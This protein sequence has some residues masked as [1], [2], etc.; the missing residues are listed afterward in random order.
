VPKPGQGA[1]NGIIDEEDDVAA[2]RNRVK[3]GAN[4]E[5]VL[6]INDL[7][8]VLFKMMLLKI[9]SFFL[10]KIYKSGGRPAVDRLCIGVNKAECFGLL[11]LNGAGKTSTFK[12]NLV[13][14]LS[15]RYFNFFFYL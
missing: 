15:R 12:V 1:L 10:L 7:T 14:Y 4:D 5:H 2:E 11:G 8:K 9:S 6:A 13:S 3:I